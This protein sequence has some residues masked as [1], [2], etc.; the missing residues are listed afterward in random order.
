MISLVT[1]D[2]F[3]IVFFLCDHIFRECRDKSEGFQDKFVN[4]LM[5]VI[6]KKNLINE[7]VRLQFYI[8]IVEI[9]IK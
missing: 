7:F 4:D 6:D 2:E 9:N 5:N 8:F 1:L 3:L